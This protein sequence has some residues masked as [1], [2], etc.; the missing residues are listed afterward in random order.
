MKQAFRSDVHGGAVVRSQC[1][2]W[3]AGPASALA[4]AVRSARRCGPLAA[5]IVSVGTSLLA[6]VAQAQEAYYRLQLKHNGQFL[7]A[8]HCGSTM[9]L[10]PGSTWENGACQLWRLVPA[11]GGWSR[12]QLKHGGQYLDAAYCGNTLA[13]N[14]G[15]DWEGGACQLWRFV[16]AGE[17]WSRLQLKHGSQFLDA[18]H[19][20]TTMS[21]NPGSDWE[22]G[23][24]QLWRLVPERGRRID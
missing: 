19:C 17:G 6:P 9:S 5:L 21:L 13:L 7:D 20:G 1:S 8:D 15:S 2:Q 10:N 16:P 11:G 14:P 22:G 18:D 23:A 4:R 24:C 12:L 3:L